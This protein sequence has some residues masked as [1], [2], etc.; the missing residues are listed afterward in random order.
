MD[1]VINFFKPRGMTSHDAVYY[2][3]RLLNI[4]KVGHTGTLDPNATGVLPICIGKGTKIS[5]YLLDVDKE[6]IGQ[7][8]L[9]IATDTQDSD[10]ETILSSAK[11]VNGDEIERSFMKFKGAIQQTPPMYSALKVNGKKLYEL[12]RE[13]KVIDRKSRE[14]LIRDLIILNNYENKEI[15]FYTKCSRGTY[16][17]TLCEDIG[18]DLGTYGHMSFLIRVGVGNFKIARS[19]SMDQLD[20]MSIEELKKSITSMDKAIEHLDT[21]IVPDILYKKLVNGVLLDIGDSYLKFIDKLYRIYSKNQFIGVGK[22]VLK[23]NKPFL[24]MDKL[25]IQVRQWK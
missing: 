12:A 21:I 3:R 5:E 18:N 11:V 14:V 2:F 22:I 1:G 25:L 9:G 13:G 4:K 6:Y 17:R 20:N 7:L 24:K 15:L 16:I 23:N 10:G 19:F 8:T